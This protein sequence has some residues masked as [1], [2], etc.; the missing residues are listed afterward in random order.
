MRRVSARPQME[1]L[2]ARMLLSA[3]ATLPTGQYLS[4][5]EALVPSVV[6]AE[7]ND[8]VSTYDIPGMGVA[9]TYQGS[10]ILDRGYGF[11][12]DSSG[13]D[14]TSTPPVTTSTPFAVGSVSKIFTAIATL[15][16]AQDPALIDT[17]ANPGITSLDLDAP[18]GTYLPPDV[19]IKLPGLPSPPPDDADTFTLPTNWADLTTRELLLMS[20]GTPDNSGTTPWNEVIAG[21]TKYGIAPLVFSPP[22]S[23]YFY[24][25]DGFKVLGALIEELTGMTYAQFVQNEIFNPLGMDQSIVLTGTDTAESVPGAAVGYDSYD[26]SSGMGKATPADKLFTGY[27]AFSGGAVVTT[28]QDLAI[29]LSALWNQSSL[30]LDPSMYQLMW[31]PVSLP[32]FKNPGNYVTPGMGWD[33]VNQTARDGDP[34]K[35]GGTRLS[36]SDQSLHDRRLRDRGRRECQQPKRHLG[37][38]HTRRRDQ[39]RPPHNH[40]PYLRPGHRGSRRTAARWLASQHR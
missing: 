11:T 1:I 3:S 10:V 16:I 4:A 34:Q 8:L 32:D 15:M 39:W 35:R 9:I 6:G 18:I 21:Y 19:A 27:S 26:P 33:G 37:R 24:S 13:A 40:G 2:D 31:T 36:G 29:Y 38:G 7:V 12:G 14:A 28:A 5:L 22:G 30:L 17:S 23:Q 20:S 25:D